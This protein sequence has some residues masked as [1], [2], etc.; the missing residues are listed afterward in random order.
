[1]SFSGAAN[2]LDTRTSTVS[3]RVRDFEDEIGIALFERTTAGVRLTDAGDRL[4][5]EIIPAIRSIELALHNAST[6][7]RAECGTVRIGIVT[8]LA[9][10]FLRELIASFRDEFGSVN[11]DI[12]DGG[13]QDHLLAIRSRDLDVAFVTGNAPQADFDVVELWRERIH[14][15]MAA[16]HP[17]ARHMALDWPQLRGEQLLITAHEPGSEVRDYIIRRTA[18]YSTDPDVSARSVSQETLMHLVA[19]GE[20]ITLVSEGRTSTT[21]PDL[22][23]RPLS[24]LEDIVPFSAVWSPNNDNPAFRRFLSM[25]RAKTAATRIAPISQDYP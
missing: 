4:V 24:A 17:L 23:F 18:D 19:I 1:L 14:V 2:A 6:A 13:R 5:K 8:T 3:R 9:S 7:G 22:A 20:G 16:T 10:G 12:H 25:A 11:L 15:A 21:Y